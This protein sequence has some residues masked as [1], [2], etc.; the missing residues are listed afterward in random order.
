M[1]KATRPLVIYVHREEARELK[2]NRQYYAIER[3]YYRTRESAQAAADREYRRRR[4]QAERGQ[5]PDL[6]HRQIVATAQL[7]P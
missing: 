7:E 2:G 1:R 4:E 5:W 3:G 6:Y